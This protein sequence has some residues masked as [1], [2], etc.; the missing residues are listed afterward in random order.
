MGQRPGY[1]QG[2]PVCHPHGTGAN[3]GATQ[4]Q[5]QQ[6]KVLTASVRPGSQG[7]QQGARPVSREDKIDKDGS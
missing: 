1:P 6:S 2:T 4:V 7:A 3:T 5:L